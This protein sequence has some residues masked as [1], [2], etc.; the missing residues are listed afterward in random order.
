MPV[1]SKNLYEKHGI[2]KKIEERKKKE[3][4][5]KKTPVTNVVV[6][7]IENHEKPTQ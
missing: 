2:D 3:K 4:M 1:L 5:T 7:T 6:N